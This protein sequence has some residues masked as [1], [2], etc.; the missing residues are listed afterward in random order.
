MNEPA[1]EL[2]DRE[3]FPEEDIRGMQILNAAFIAGLLMF[4]G[5]TIFLYFTAAEPKVPQGKMK[6][7]IEHLSIAN[8]V[9][10]I[11]SSAAGF[12]IFRSRLAPIAKACSDSPHASP[13]DFLGELRGAFILRLAMLEG[14]GLLGTVVC[15]F[16]VTGSEIHDHPIYWL[17][18]LSPIA[19]ITFMG[20]TFPT[21]EKL[22]RLFLDEEQSLYR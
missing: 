11:L 15:F 17:N 16:G 19:A 1:A 2:S 14:P 18:L 7:A 6:Q 20:V 13:I 5:V 10:F 12:F 4:V 21:Q 8:A 3:P 9:V 22:S